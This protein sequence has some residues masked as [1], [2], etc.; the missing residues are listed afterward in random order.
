[1]IAKVGILKTNASI[2][3][4]VIKTYR[5]M[6]VKAANLKIAFAQNLE[7]GGKKLENLEFDLTNAV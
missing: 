4:K 5:K 7:N 6:C 2:Q 1:M 3:H